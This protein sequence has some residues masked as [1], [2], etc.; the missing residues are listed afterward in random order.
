MIC[1]LQQ[2]H[3][4]CSIVLCGTFY[5]KV[6]GWLVL[7]T[8]TPIQTSEACPDQRRN[9]LHYYKNI[10]TKPEPSN[11][12]ALGHMNLYKSSPIRP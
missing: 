2:W 10:E 5:V 1:D 4:Y 8:W 12:M 3:P 9:T 7:T 6:K 11:A